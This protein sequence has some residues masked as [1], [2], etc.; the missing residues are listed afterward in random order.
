MIQK[1]R[2]DRVLRL[3]EEHGYVT[4]KFLVDEL[5]YS[6]ATI[7]R[8]LNTLAQMGKVKRTW[9]GVEPI[10][11]KVIPVLFRYEYGK[12]QKR[13]IA[14][15]AAEEIRDGE[16]VFIDG[17]T[18]AQHMSEYLLEKKDLRVLTHNLSLAIFLAENGV[19]VTVLGGKILESPYMLAGTD[20]VETASRYRA[21]RCFFSTHDV[22]DKGQMSY[23]DDIYF[24]LHRTM[25]RNSDSVVYLVDSDKINRRGGKVILG[26]FSLVDMVIS[27][28]DFSDRVKETYP[29]VKFIM[30]E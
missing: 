23:T 2:L 1:E 12:S 5:H 8:D 17:S 29:N 13:R 26:D 11:A 14:K 9:G 28:Y 3:I 18:T 16:T 15:R 27:D 24:S 7:N 4:V 25:M 20:A 6:K 21:D 30:A 22:T 19:D 10:Q